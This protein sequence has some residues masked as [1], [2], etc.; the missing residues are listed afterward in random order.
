MRRGAGPR[1]LPLRP[2]GC[3]WRRRVGSASANPWRS[4]L[5]GQCRLLSISRSSVY[6]TPQGERAQNLEL[7]RR[8]DGLFLKYPFYGSRQ[9]VRHSWRNGVRV[10]R[11]RGSASDAGDR[12]TG[13]LSGAADHQTASRAP[14]LLKG[15]AIERPNQGLDRGHHLYP[16]PARLP[17]PGGDHGLGYSP[18]ALLTTVQYPRCP[19]LHRG[20][21]RSP[22]AIQ[23][24]SD[25]QYRPRQP[26]HQPRV[27]RHLKDAGVPISMDGS[28][29]CMANIFIER[30]CRSLKY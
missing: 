24:A 20:P 17:V 28:G 13:R 8:I 3:N 21:H 27:H 30:L 14:D 4:S 29:R 23:P 12:A 15:L 26:V 5:S 18:C 25:L 2:R 7:M 6:H 22:G 1:T 19:L 16:R 9:M 10:G 11:H